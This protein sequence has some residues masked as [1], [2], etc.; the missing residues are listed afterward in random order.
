MIKYIDIQSSIYS[1][2]M[3]VLVYID[4]S[5]AKPI[6]ACSWFVDNILEFVCTVYVSDLK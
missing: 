4:L 1:W 6:Y 5:Y 3:F 2:A